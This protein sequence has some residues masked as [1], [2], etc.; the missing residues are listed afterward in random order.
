V[1]Y[2]GTTGG[3]KITDE[4]GYTYYYTKP[5]Y[6]NSV[7][8]GKYPLNN[9]YSTKN[10]CTADTVRSTDSNGNYYVKDVALTTDSNH[11]YMVEWKQNASYVY[12]WLLTSII[13]PDY[14]DSNTDG[15]VNSTD[16][17]Y[18]VLYD[19]QKWTD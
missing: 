3:F 5:V 12:S 14:I 15:Y 2:L 7:V 17:G 16:K 11:P 13:G 10:Y 18:W 9:D 8:Y 1:E 19:Y 4:N 6:I